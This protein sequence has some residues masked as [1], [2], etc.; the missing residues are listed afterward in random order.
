MEDFGFE[1]FKKPHEIIPNAD[2]FTIRRWNQ[3]RDKF[4]QITFV[5]VDTKN[6]L[7]LPLHSMIRANFI[8][9]F[10]DLERVTGLK[11]DWEKYDDLLS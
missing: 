1:V 11:I 10:G 3:T 2:M 8:K 5:S 6:T 9:H 7:M 4:K